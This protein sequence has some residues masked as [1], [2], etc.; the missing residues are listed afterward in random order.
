MATGRLFALY[1][2]S[3]D[4]RR[5]EQSVAKSNGGYVHVCT[6]M[7]DLVS[8]DRGLR[9]VSGKQMAGLVLKERE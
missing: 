2:D 9:S 7:A 8:I 1:Y 6:I 4:S 5:G 3:K